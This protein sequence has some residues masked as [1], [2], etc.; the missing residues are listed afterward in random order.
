MTMNYCGKCGSANGSTAR[1]CRQ[2]GTEL[3]GQTAFSSQSTPLNVEFSTKTAPRERENDEA[4]EA[5]EFTPPPVIAVESPRPITESPR[6]A[7]PPPP[8][9]PPLV[10]PPVLAKSKKKTP[11]P[12]N[13]PKAI[14]DALKTLRAM[15]AK[16]GLEAS[17]PKPEIIE[18]LKVE[19]LEAPKVEIIEAPKVEIIEPPNVVVIEPLPPLPPPPKPAVNTAPLPAPPSIPAKP[20]EQIPPPPKPAAPERA[21]N[22]TRDSG[23]GSQRPPA[24][25]KAENGKGSGKQAPP[26]TAA[27]KP[28]SSI[29][30][31]A[32]Q[33]A[34][35]AGAA[36]PAVSVARK[37]S[38]SLSAYSSGSLSLA[39]KNRPSLGG[40]GGQ[41]QHV[42]HGPS[43][44]LVQ[45]S[46]LKPQSFGSKFLA[47]V[48]ILAILI[49]MGTYFIVR[50]YLLAARPF[51]ETD[52]VLIRAED[53]SAEFLKQGELFRSQ[54]NFSASIDQL[55]RALNLTP[56][57]QQ[58]RYLLGLAYTAANQEEEA[59]KTYQ[60]LLRIAPEHLD[61]RLRV[62]EIYRARGNW[63]AAYQELQRVIAFDQNSAQAREALGII[64]KIRVEAASQLT[65]SDAAR[66]A[67]DL[68]RQKKKLPVLPA[69]LFD[70]V[71]PPI[72][73]LRES[74][75]AAVRPPAQLTAPEDPGPQ[76]LADSHKKLGVR[77]LNIREYRAAINEFLL[78]L[79]LSPNDKDLYYF[80]GSSYNGLNQPAIAHDYYRRVDAG[81][82]VGPAQSGA[83]LTEKAA[84]E[85]NKRREQLKNEFGKD[86]GALLPNK[87]FS[88]RVDD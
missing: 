74:P 10:P 44:V 84:K 43:S 20:L 31:Q 78:A 30:M 21:P 63:P 66:N 79:R 46:G 75:A 41:L 64:E 62:A 28:A 58:A 52:K 39:L 56:N 32:R 22:N 68:K 6:P 14:S 83:R 86:T 3:N 47:G 35:A 1:F 77:Y 57:S 23:A 82:Y 2:C 51:S 60:Y 9:P 70:S 19:S 25:R 33:Q 55:Q 18:P 29:S 42:A 72:V 49:S 13:D 38:E 34:M 81:P 36:P 15:A 87:S 16:N 59:L 73:P 76:D 50:D 37:N 4:P 71:G 7:P 45:A 54:G 12:E 40:S 5:R 53:Q 11:P 88:N 61:G 85:E 17:A 48:I 67:N 26:R 69:S 65:A 27:G 8:P 80:I 24:N